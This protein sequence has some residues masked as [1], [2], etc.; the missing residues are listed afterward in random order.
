MRRILAML[1]AMALVAVPVSSWGAP[2]AYK[3]CAAMNKAFPNGVAQSAKFKNIGKSPIEKPKVDAKAYQANKKLDT[4]KDGIA[5]ERLKPAND[6]SAQPNPSNP[7]DSGFAKIDKNSWRVAQAA[8]LN[9]IAAGT[10]IPVFNYQVGPQLDPSRLESR[11][12]AMAAAAK[13]WSRWFSPVTVE[14]IYWSENDAAWAEDKLAKSWNYRANLQAVANGER[15]NCGSAGANGDPRVVSFHE[16][17]GSNLG[18]VP[19]SVQTTPH[20]YTHLF[21]NQHGGCALYDWYCEGGAAYFGSTIGNTNDTDGSKRLAQLRTWSG[22]LGANRALIAAGDKAT[23]VRLLKEWQGGSHT[24]D[25]IAGSYFLGNLATEV[26]VAA[27]G[28]ET[29]AS[30]TVAMSTS[31]DFEANFKKHYGIGLAEFYEIVAS[32]L[33]SQPEIFN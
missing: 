7:A 19:S 9:G 24:R 2:T 29:W 10:T 1:M 8:V 18:N 12:V 23:V 21:Q 20:E 28:V 30:F 33:V 17:V 11:K 14:A 26:L 5:C 25:A 31:N 32:Y 27:K 16:C 6:S 4:D 22:N 3:N 15:G 13:L